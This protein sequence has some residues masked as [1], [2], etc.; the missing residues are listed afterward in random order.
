MAPYHD[1]PD[2]QALAARLN[3][4]L[5]EERSKTLQLICFDNPAAEVW[6]PLPETCQDVDAAR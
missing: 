1:D 3:K 2:F 6:Q 4:I 5:E